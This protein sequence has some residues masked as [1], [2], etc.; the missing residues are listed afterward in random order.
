MT[1]TPLP[2]ASLTAAQESLTALIEATATSLWDVSATIQ[3]TKTVSADDWE[4][5]RAACSH[6]LLALA[7]P[8]AATPQPASRPRHESEVA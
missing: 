4:L 5:A 7:H 6:L 3:S 1:P 8:P 2:T